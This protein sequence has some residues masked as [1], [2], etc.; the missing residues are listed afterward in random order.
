VTGRATPSGSRRQTVGP[1]AFPGAAAGNRRHV[2]RILLV[3]LGI[4]IYLPAVALMTIQ[5]AGANE[6]Q[7]LFDWVTGRCGA[8]CSQRELLATAIQIVPIVVT[9][10]VL[11]WIAYI[12]VKRGR[13]GDR[14][15]SAIEH[16]FDTAPERVS[17]YAIDEEEQDER[18]LYRDRQGR[19]RPVYAPPPPT[20]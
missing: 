18:Y 3:V 6:L 4:V 13:R 7:A 10:P 14:Q 20:P 5:V 11:A 17:P 12:W 1:G 2:I 8:N 16:H 9:A 15:V 19:L